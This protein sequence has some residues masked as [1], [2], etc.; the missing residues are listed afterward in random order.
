MVEQELLSARQRLE[1]DCAKARTYQN[2][3]EQLQLGRQQELVL[4]YE[5][6]KK[7]L[8]DLNNKEKNLIKKE[9]ADNIALSEAEKNLLQSSEKLRL[10]Q[11]N[12]KALGEDKLL[13]VQ[14]ELAGLDTQTR[15]LERQALQHQK[16]G[17]R[18]KEKRED[19]I[20]CIL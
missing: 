4:G 9:E 12:V 8:I 10:L 19:L 2:L 20:T 14:A 16:E 17:E 15:E 5:A 13:K 11:E 1:R 3:R 6:T 18:L 7:N